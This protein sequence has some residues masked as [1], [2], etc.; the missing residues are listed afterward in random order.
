MGLVDAVV[1]VG[2]A[3]LAHP[4][5]FDAALGVLGAAGRTR[6]LLVV[7]G[8]G[9]FA[10]AVR[11]VDRRLGLSNDAAHWMAVLAMDQ[12]AH[13]IASRLA[14]SVLVTGPADIRAAFSQSTAD[15]AQL[16][17]GLAPVLS[18]RSAVH[19]MV[20]VLAPYRWLRDA[21]PLPHSWDVTSDSIAAW[22]GG[23]IG[24]ERLVLVKPPGATEGELVDAYFTR[25]LPAH[26]KSVIV[27][28]DQIG[29]LGA[30]LQG[31]SAQRN[32]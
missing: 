20:P 27:P 21:D 30:A 8:G 16:A 26:I 11:E 6:R 14:G 15:T 2:G 1:K 17:E 9:P 29:A 24:A 32:S 5:H 13:L 18:A 23:Q 31:T 28:G 12:Y 19:L 7:P 22:V 3:L 4:A 10:D 25:A